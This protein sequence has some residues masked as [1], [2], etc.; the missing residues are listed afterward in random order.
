MPHPDWLGLVVDPEVTARDN[1]HLVRRLS[2]AK[3][4]QAATPIE[5]VDFAPLVVSTP[6]P[7]KASPLANGSASTTISSSSVRPVPANLGWLARSA[8]GPAAMAFRSSTSARPACSPISAR[9]LAKV[10]LHA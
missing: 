5:N 4:R 7:F 8:T 2:N 9:R 10:V 6:P 1:R 3:L